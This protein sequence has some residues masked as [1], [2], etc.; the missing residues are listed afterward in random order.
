LLNIGLVYLGSRF[1]RKHEERKKRMLQLVLVWLIG[2]LCFFKYVPLLLDT[3]LALRSRLSFIPAFEA[4]AILLPLGLSYIIFR[5]IHYIVEVYRNKAPSSSFIDFA[6]YVL[7]FPTFIAGPVERFP[8]FHAQTAGRDDFELSKLNDGLLR[9]LSGIAKKFIVA[10]Y[11][12][13]VVMPMLSSP[14]EYSRYII[15]LAIYG[16]A[17]QIYMDFSGYTDM[18]LGVARLFGY[19]IMENFNYP[20]FKKNIAL[21]WRNWHISVYSFIRDYFF[22]PLF[23]YRAST[24]KIYLGVFCTMLVFMLWHEGSLN[25][26]MLGVYHGL[27]LI[28]WNLYQE[29]KRKYAVL[30]PKKEKRYA[31]L[32]STWMTFTFVS[33]GFVI[34]MFDLQAIGRI[35]AQVF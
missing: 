21:F 23:G 34:F 33:F 1:I 25:F 13:G 11:L 15:V 5:M 35:L 31:T 28:I 18:A 12:K 20:Y 3:V 6:L 2:N 30:R 9:I 8:R 24:K 17:I 16:L 14:E 10:D 29:L 19:K 7:F 27:G 26:M 32:M 22:F 4:P